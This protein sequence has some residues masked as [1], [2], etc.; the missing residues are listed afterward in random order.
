MRRLKRGRA[1]T[2]V[3]VVCPS[4][5]LILLGACLATLAQTSSLQTIRVIGGGMPLRVAQ[6]NGLLAKYGIE[7][8]T[9][10]MANSDSMRAD[11]A[12]GRADIAN[13]AV[14]NAVAL[15]ELA[16]ADVIIVL[17]ESGSQNELIAQPDYKSV[18]DLQGKTLIVDAPNTALALEMKKIL[19]LNGLKPGVDCEI[20]PVGVTSRRLAAMRED[21]SYAASMMGPPTSLLAKR[22]GFVSLGSVQQL[23]GQ[24]QGGG[25]FVRR[26][27]A[28]EHAGLLERYIAANVAAQRWILAPANKEKVLEIMTRDLKLPPD[29]A[30]ETYEVETN[31]PGGWAKDLQFDLE[32]FKNVLKLRAEVEGS[33]GGKPPAPDK[34]YD[35]S[36][37]HAALSKLKPAQ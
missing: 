14:D 8:Q 17:G 29:V 16:G 20:K 21:K 32:G 30:A 9:S 15:V 25:A 33:W 36:Y 1:M 13:A 10:A 6:M 27:W 11:L 5:A 4:F 2:A 26:Q 12:A 24:Y 18:K 37:Y 19:M 22:G 3:S 31:A 7:A 28:K 23:L 35:L 34:Y